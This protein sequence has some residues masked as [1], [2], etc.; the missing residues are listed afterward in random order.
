M[1]D[2]ERSASPG[3]AAVGAITE[4]RRRRG[5]PLRLL[6]TALVVYGVVGLVLLGVVGTALAAPIEDL[7]SIS[8]SVEAQRTAA[9]DSLTRASE[10]IDRTAE[11]VR[12]MDTSLADAQA[13]TNRSATIALGVATSMTQ[14]A[15]SMTL[16]IF[17]VQP[18]IGLQPGFANSAAQ[19]NLLAVDLA[20]IGA[21]LQANREDALIVAGSLDELSSSLERLTNAVRDGPELEL[22]AASLDTVRIG[23][24]ALLAWL[25]VLALGCVGAGIG[26]WWVAGRS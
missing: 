9:L 12:G 6:G 19:L 20:T 10:T 23:V 7:S 4:R 14:L 3:T 25:A 11:A 21:A 8:G 26:C 13:A 2:K 22:A 5:G 24:L 1:S 15:D 17:G 18:L 16:T